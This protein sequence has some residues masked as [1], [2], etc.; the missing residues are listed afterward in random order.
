[1]YCVTV[2]ILIF[3]FYKD[4]GLAKILGEFQ[5]TKT[6]CGTPMYVGMYYYLLSL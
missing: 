2:F 3:Y 5:S 6:L 4:F 1:M